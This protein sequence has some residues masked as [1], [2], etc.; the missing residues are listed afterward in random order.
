[1]AE[2]EIEILDLGR[3]A[4][5]EVHGAMLERVE[6]LRQDG[7]DAVWLVEHEGVFTAG[8]ATPAAELARE[9]VIAIE[10][11]GQVTWHGPGQLVVYPLLRLPRRDLR[12]WLKALEAFGIAV[13]AE[14]GLQ[15][16]ASVDGTGVFVAGKK[17]AS[18][19][20]AVRHWV[21]F[22]G[23]AL[24]VDVDLAGF[25]GI[26]PCGLDPGVMSDLSRACGRTVSLEEAKAA[27]RRC[28]PPLLRMDPA[29]ERG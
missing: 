23:I 28:L 27:A 3:R 7:P 26:Q 22:H 5:A 21:N 19:G 4:Y 29:A 1:M 12:A 9:D 8:R 13:C 25:A 6:A 2:P 17:L 16:E 15:A 14:F 24:N 11:G 10:R 20:V 18:I